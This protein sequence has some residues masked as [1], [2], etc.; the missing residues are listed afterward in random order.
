MSSTLLSNEHT[1]R[2]CSVLGSAGFCGQS[3]EQDRPALRLAQW[4][5]QI[6][7]C[8]GPREKIGGWGRRGSRLGQERLL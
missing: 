8:R 2:A 1:S 4:E 6:D 3:S 7:Q 5:R